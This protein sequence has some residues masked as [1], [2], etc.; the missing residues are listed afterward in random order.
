MPLMAK[1]LPLPSI[2][3]IVIRIAVFAFISSHLL[4]QG[5]Q[6]RS[7][8]VE[9]VR[10]QRRMAL[11][12]GNQNYPHAP[13]KNPFNDAAAVAQVL[14]SLAF[15]EVIEFRDL[16]LRRMRQE[17]DRF[18]ARVEPG[19]LALFYYAGHGVQAN[20][21]N[22]LIPVDFS[23]TSEADLEYEAYPGGQVRDK[24]ER[25]GARLRIL[26]LDACRNN[27]FHTT[28]S[29]TRGLAPMASSV[30]GTYI[31]FSTADNSVADDSPSDANGLF[32]KYL[33]GA[34]R[35]P[36][37]GLKQIFEKTKEEVYFASQKRQR[38]F[39][40]DGVVGQFYFSEPVVVPVPSRISPEDV[41]AQEEIAFWNA[42][43]KN[44]GE[45]LDLYLRQ[46][47]NGRFA[48][49]A[50][51]SLTKLNTSKAANVE[52][53]SPTKS[54]N[55]MK[56]A[57][58]NESGPLNGQATNAGATPVS[59]L[60]S[61]ATPKQVIVSPKEFARNGEFKDVYFDLGSAQVTS[62]GETALMRNAEI[63]RL[64][65]AQSGQAL[66]VIEGY[67]G[68][69]QADEAA[70]RTGELRAAAAKE[71]LVKHGLPA[72]R[73]TIISYGNERL[74]CIEQTDSCQQQNRRAHVRAQE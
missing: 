38:P 13:L 64:L 33:L 2:K 3:S 74:V 60:T 29:A 66:V 31:A 70:L 56:S 19:D 48:S 54:A 41:R 18:A 9:P 11:V 61:P 67:S 15:G 30:E 1:L 59:L 55:S 27:P 14:R 22:Y 26:I 39:T 72:S 6:R 71:L 37:L 10:V 63:I 25:S 69:V 21:Q 46:Y 62:D 68:D 12:I 49:I 51:R 34:L 65:F 44:D 20:E 16:T 4:A 40:Y 8:H 42:V 5:D 45:S 36:G 58:P 73:I 28:R 35:T 43:D 47:Q 17:I 52:S 24:L 7:L 23:G 50:R 53:P 32:T 57:N